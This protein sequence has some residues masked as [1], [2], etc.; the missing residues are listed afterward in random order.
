[1]SAALFIFCLDYVDI[2]WKG[3][4][5]LNCMCC[6]VISVLGADVVPLSQT[7][8]GFNGRAKYH[9]LESQNVSIV[10]S[11]DFCHECERKQTHSTRILIR[12]TMELHCLTPSKYV[13]VSAIDMSP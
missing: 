4:F 2:N 7:A 5:V 6:S 13:S 9:S 3:W 12:T 11:P 1:M 10:G 8:C